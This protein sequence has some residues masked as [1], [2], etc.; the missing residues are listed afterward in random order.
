MGLREPEKI[1]AAPTEETAEP[2]IE[3]TEENPRG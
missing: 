2:Q 1:E 3:E